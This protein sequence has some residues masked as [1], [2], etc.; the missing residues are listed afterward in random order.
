VTIRR[1]Y[2]I[3]LFC[4]SFTPSP[5]HL[6]TGASRPHELPHAPPSP[7]R[8]AFRPRR[9]VRLLPAPPPQQGVRAPPRPHRGLRRRRPPSRHSKN[10]GDARSGTPPL[11][12]RASSS[13]PAWSRR[14][15]LRR[16][17]RLQLGRVGP[18]PPP[19]R[20]RGRTERRHGN[21]RPVHRFVCQARA[22]TN[23]RRRPLQGS[24]NR[25]GL[26]TPPWID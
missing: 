4:S 10:D 16:R 14:E 20:P 17:T 22:T 24:E 5:N 13:S 12:R 1:E 9:A 23:R 26:S 6:H 3:L 11:A 8:C 21:G 19:N 2:L 18:C 7:K 15:A 25:T